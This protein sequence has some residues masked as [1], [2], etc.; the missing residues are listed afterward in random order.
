MS[1]PTHYYSNPGVTSHDVIGLTGMYR[2][3]TK[4][5]VLCYCGPSRLEKVTAEGA[6]NKHVKSLLDTIVGLTHTTH[7]FI[8]LQSIGY[9]A[10]Y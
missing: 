7:I 2:Q 6:T 4:Q 8:N 1:K 3:V 5:V 9:L 10:R